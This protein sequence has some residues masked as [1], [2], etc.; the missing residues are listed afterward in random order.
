MTKAYNKKKKQLDEMVWC[1]VGSYVLPAV[2][3]AVDRCL[4]GK[5]SSAEYI[6][7]PI[8]HNIYDEMT[9]EERENMEMRKLIEAEEQWIRVSKQKGLPET[10]IR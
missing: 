5:K 8:L 9:E 7:E 2:L 1:S 3:V 6:K 10:I 4:N